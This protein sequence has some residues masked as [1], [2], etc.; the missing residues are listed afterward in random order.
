[1]VTVNIGK[2]ALE[3]VAGDIT[4]QDTEAVVTSFA[5]HKDILEEM[6]LL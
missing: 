5:V 6:G 3:L 2:S 1:M 4:Q